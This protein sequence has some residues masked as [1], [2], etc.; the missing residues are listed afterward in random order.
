MTKALFVIAPKDFKDVEYLTPK[1]ILADGGVETITA[2]LEKQAIGID[3]AKIEV[4]LLLDE[5]NEIYDAII[6]IGG[7]GSKIYFENTKAHELI[8]KHNQ[9]GKI[10][11]AICIAPTILANAGILQGKKATIFPGFDKNLKD[12][13]YTGEKVTVDNNIVTASDPTAAGLFGL[14]LLKKLK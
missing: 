9:E 3:G 6:F 11:A 7:P 1:Q 12:A 4:D 5:V 8:K 13:N 2:S 14:E 10:I